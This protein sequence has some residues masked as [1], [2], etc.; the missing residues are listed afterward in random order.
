MILLQPSKGFNSS[1]THGVP[2][3][4]RTD[5]LADCF[6]WK[7]VP[8]HRIS[9]AYKTYKFLLNKPIV[10]YIHLFLNQ[11]C[12]LTLRLFLCVFHQLGFVGFFFQ[13]H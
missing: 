3:E 8:D 7:T 9:I 13:F 1:E 5:S 12:I 4:S 10:A 6:Y 2:T 11:N